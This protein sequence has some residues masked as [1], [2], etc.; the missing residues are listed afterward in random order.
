[1]AGGL[2]AYSQR[3]G[4]HWN[5]SPDVSPPRSTISEP[6]EADQGRLFFIHR[7]CLTANLRDPRGL[8]ASL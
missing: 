2:Q 1:M 8:Q 6:P 5:S 3:L 7:A 4:R